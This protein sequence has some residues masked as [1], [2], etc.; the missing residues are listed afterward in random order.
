M[1]HPRKATTAPGQLASALS[2]GGAR[3]G[4]RR[5]EL[6]IARRARRG[7]GERLM[8]KTVT[9]IRAD[10]ETCVY[11]VYTREGRRRGGCFNGKPA[12]GSNR[13][14]PGPVVR[15]KKGG[16]RRAA[17]ECDRE[18][19]TRR[20]ARSCGAWPTLLRTGVQGMYVGEGLT[21]R[22]AACHGGYKSYEVSG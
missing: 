13:P 9:R 17:N 1:S 4:T 2:G 5:L 6:R 8:F 11:G 22:C 20:D 18:G 10:R 12:R 15:L 14:G 16:P 19:A 7:Q 21:G 3:R